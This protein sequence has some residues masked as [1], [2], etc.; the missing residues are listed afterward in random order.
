MDDRRLLRMDED[1][2]HEFF[3]RSNRFLL[4]TAANLFRSGHSNNIGG[5]RFDGQSLFDMQSVCVEVERLAAVGFWSGIDKAAKTW[6][7]RCTLHER[8]QVL[9]RL[10]GPDFEQIFDKSGD[11][12]TP[13]C[14]V[15]RLVHEIEEMLPDI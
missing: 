8:L 3:T 7:F 14:V 15:G 9:H 10:N 5:H 6:M 4:S 2:R 11:Y 12:A 13:D 1:T